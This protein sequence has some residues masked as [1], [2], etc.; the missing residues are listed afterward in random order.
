MF[1]FIQ[2]RLY[3]VYLIP[4]LDN[5]KL[6]DNMLNFWNCISILQTYHCHNHKLL[7]Q[8]QNDL[9]SLLFY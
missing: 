6:V 9:T 5:I 1:N 3:T 8:E 4:E 7:L 2:Y